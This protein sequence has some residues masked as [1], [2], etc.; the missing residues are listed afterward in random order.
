MVRLHGISQELGGKEVKMIVN[1]LELAVL[2]KMI[3]G[4]RCVAA[5]YRAQGVRCFEQPEF[6]QSMFF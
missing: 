4:P 1:W 2:V 3:H 6:C 5:S